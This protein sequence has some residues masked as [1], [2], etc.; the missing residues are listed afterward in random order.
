MRPTALLLL[1]LT[2]TA[3][4]GQNPNTTATAPKT[5]EPTAKHDAIEYAAGDAKLEGYLAYPDGPA[6]KRPGVVVFHDWMGLGPNPKMRADMLATLGYVALAADLY[7]KGV[8][9]ANAGEAGKLAGQY[10]EDRVT[11]RARAPRRS[12]SR[13]AAR[14]SRPR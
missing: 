3:C 8:R 7:G 14:R 13:G 4:S 6:T 10:K 5:V 1:G 12:S 11:L 9:P 2:L